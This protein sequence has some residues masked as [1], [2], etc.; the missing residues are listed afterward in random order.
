MTLMKVVVLVLFIWS[1]YLNE[2]VKCDLPV[3]CVVNEIEGEWIMRI[4]KETFSPSLQDMRTTCGHGFPNRVDNSVGDYDYKFD[5]YYDINV[6]LDKS[7]NVHENGQK[8]GYWTPVYDQSFV[9]YYKNSIFTAPY[10]YFKS[11]NDKFLSNCNKSE[12]GWLVP[13]KDNLEHGWSCFF[14][15]KKGTDVSNYKGENN[16]LHDPHTA[17]APTYDGDA[18]SFAQISTENKFSS[19]FKYDSFDKVVD[20]INSADL[21]WKAKMYDQFKGFSFLQVRDKLGMKKTKKNSKQPNEMGYFLNLNN[22]RNTNRPLPNNVSRSSYSLNQGGN[23]VYLSDNIKHRQTREKDS[24]LVTDY[25]E[26]AKY[27]NTPLD[28][29]PEETLPL[30]WDWRNVGGV[31]YVTEDVKVQGECGSCYVFST[32]S[33]L[34]SR[35]RIRTNNKDKTQFSKEFPLSYNFYSEGCDGGYPFLVGKFFNE[36]EIIPED[37][38]PYKQSDKEYNKICDYKNIYKKKYRVSNYGYL[39]GFYGATNEVMMLKEL[40]ARGPFPGNILVP[41][42]FNLYSHGIYSHSQL[43]KNSEKLST[44]RMIDRKATW[45][46]VEHSITIV[47]YGE[48]NGIKFWIGKNTWGDNWGEDGYFRVLRGENE[49]SIESMGDVLDIEFSDR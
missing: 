3:H 16:F 17:L 37:C 39:G 12:I 25:Q 47:G 2:N 36:F 45:E 4:N 27:L 38:L 30:N 6:T 7:Y 13:D 41:Y 48:E 21:P 15:F 22:F 24:N 19:K 49:V 28:Q 29:I 14:A 23:S 35:L 46:K 26:V 1:I 42:T 33:S 31:S 40:R 43:V 5:N 9:I 34:E 18:Y 32:I 8:V 11:F 44:T 20:E 10:K